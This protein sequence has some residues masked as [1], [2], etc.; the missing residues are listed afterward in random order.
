MP[1]D[2]HGRNLC[3]FAAK[4]VVQITAVEIT[5][6]HPRLRIVTVAPVMI[7]RQ[8]AL[9]CDRALCSTLNSYIHQFFEPWHAF[10]QER[11]VAFQPIPLAMSFT[12]LMCVDEFTVVAL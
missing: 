8:R 9:P 7:K 6:D 3:I 11:E 12:P 10:V 5:T 4:A 1:G 2:I